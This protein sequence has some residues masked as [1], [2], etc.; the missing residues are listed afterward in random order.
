[1][2]WPAA[3]YD[4]APLQCICDSIWFSLVFGAFKALFYHLPFSEMIL[5]ISYGEVW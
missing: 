3:T 1:M 4:T 2:P 5:F